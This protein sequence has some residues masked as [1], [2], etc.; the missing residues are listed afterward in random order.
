M[1][2]PDPANPHHWINNPDGTRASK[3]EPT[4][5]DEE[6]KLR[7]RISL[8]EDRLKYDGETMGN[9]LGQITTLQ[10]E[11]D[12]LSWRGIIKDLTDSHVKLIIYV[13][14]LVIVVIAIVFGIDYT[15]VASIIKALKC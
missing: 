8:L 13:S 11:V 14:G 7:V 6:R 15:T 4:A 1:T 9:L 2:Y 10:A 12:R 3:P 5:Q